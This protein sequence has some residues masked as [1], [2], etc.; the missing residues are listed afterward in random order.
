MYR[1]GANILNLDEKKSGQIIDIQAKFTET[2]HFKPPG[3]NFLEI[4]F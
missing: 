3:I 1:V 2:F 4:E